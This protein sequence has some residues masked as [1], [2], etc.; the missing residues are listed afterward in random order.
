[1]RH[2]VHDSE[3]REYYVTAMGTGRV[4]RLDE[5]GNWLGYWTVGDKP[6]TCRISPDGSRLYVSCRGPNNPDTGYL[7]RGYEYGR[8]FVINLESSEVEGWIWGRDQCTGL[9]VS[10][11]GTLL[12]FSNFL[13][14]SLE[15]YEILSR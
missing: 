3:R 12:A 14:P 8:I 9:D 5:N 10:P 4:Y 11:D 15:V 6:N 13:T 1:M 7:N 2:I